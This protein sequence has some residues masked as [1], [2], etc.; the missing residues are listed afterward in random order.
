MP[1][2]RA[3]QFLGSCP[4]SA[5]HLCSTPEILTAALSTCFKAPSLSL[6]LG[7]PRLQKSSHKSPSSHQQDELSGWSRGREAPSP[8]GWPGQTSRGP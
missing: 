4:A 8:V 5:G 3:P 1:P 6:G 7:D 2:G